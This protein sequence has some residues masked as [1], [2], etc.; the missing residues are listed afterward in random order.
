[1]LSQKNIYK[2]LKLPPKVAIEKISSKILSNGKNE[3]KR[4]K[5]YNSNTY[6]VKSKVIGL[7]SNT[8]NLPS[9]EILEQNKD[10]ILKVVLNSIEHNFNLLGSGFINIKHLN[11]YDGFEGFNY[12]EL[13]ENYWYSESKDSWL[14]KNF[15]IENQAYIK[16]LISLLPNSYHLIDWQ[17]DF[18]SG[19]RWNELDWYKDIKYGDVL[20]VDIKIPWELG[21]LQHLALFP[22][23]HQIIDNKI[24]KQDIVEEYKKQILDF[25]L[26]NP[27]RFGVQWV[28]SMDVSIRMINILVSYD[29]FCQIEIE[30]SNEFKLLVF[31]IIAIH[32]EHIENNLEFSSGMRGN[33]YLTNI[34]ALFIAGVYTSNNELVVSSWEKIKIELNYQFYNDGGNFEASTAYSKLVYELVLMTIYLIGKHK[35]IL[36][37]DNNTKTKLE[38]IIDFNL[39]TVSNLGEHWNFGDND[40]GVVLLSNYMSNRNSTNVLNINFKNVI[41]VLFENNQ[42]SKHTIKKDFGIY[43]VFNDKYESAISFAPVGQNGKGGHSHNDKLS[44]CLN[45]GSEQVVVDPGTYCYTSSRE[46]RNKYRSTDYHNTLII[47]GLEQNTFVNFEKDDLFWIKEEKAKVNIIS[48]NDFTFI[49]EHNAYKKTH[50]RAFLFNANAIICK[51]LCEVNG[52]KKV[53]FHFAPNVNLEKQVDDRTL[54]FKSMNT[55]YL[56]SIDNGEFEVD[57]YYYSPNYG[58]KIK[59]TKVSVLFENNELNWMFEIK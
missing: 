10:F 22:I 29:Y 19:F 53:N 59:A 13:R 47:N 56:L 31:K 51:D 11:K 58:E 45:V 1:M 20:G 41:E 9:N 33:H 6:D 24:V 44:F 16:S 2:L 57:S 26:S 46:L 8:F 23:A 49:A 17:I 15:A 50:K 35:L 21:R 14:K 42:K 34:I 12:S 37:I 30:F 27:P 32:I 25:H 54:K 52:I 3:K 40:S 38:Q 55:N 36:E 18:R 4:A 43:N 48:A 39:K 28:T 7:K 5:D